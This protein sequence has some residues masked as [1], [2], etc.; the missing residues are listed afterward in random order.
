MLFLCA[1]ACGRNL[2]IQHE[3][4]MCV[5]DVG[6]FGGGVSRSGNEKVKGNWNR[7]KLR[8]FKLAIVYFVSFIYLIIYK[9]L[10]FF[11]LNYASCMYF[12][13]ILISVHNFILF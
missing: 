11:N 6:C 10:F 3:K 1:M 2:I 13:P 8:G 7:D 5:C 4:G 12:D 9:L